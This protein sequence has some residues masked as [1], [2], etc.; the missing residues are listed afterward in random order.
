MGMAMRMRNENGRRRTNG[1]DWSNVLIKRACRNKYLLTRSRRPQKN[2][3][4]IVAEW[5]K[6]MAEG[7][8]QIRAAPTNQ[9]KTRS[10]LRKFKLYTSNV[11][12]GVLIYPGTF[13]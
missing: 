5:L 2:R 1:L 6:L 3:N 13:I 11:P 8:T 10:E 12:R 4:Q 9:G 7:A